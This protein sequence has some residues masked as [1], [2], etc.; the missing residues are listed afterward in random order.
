M[1]ISELYN[2][3]KD[4]S[5]KKI[6]AETKDY[7]IG[8]L[9]NIN[10][11]NTKE[12]AKQFIK[13]LALCRGAQAA[14]E[15]ENRTNTLRTLLS[16]G[17]DGAYVENDS[18]INDRF[19]YELI[20]N[21]DDC[22]YASVSDCKLKI[23]F[24]F[25]NDTL[26]LAYN[27]LG[28]RPKDVIAI[29]DIGNSTKNHHKSLDQKESGLEDADLIEIG[30]KGIGFKSIF[31][32]ADKVYIRSGYFGFYFDYSDFTIPK[33][34][35]GEENHVDGTEL[36]IYLKPEITKQ[37]YKM[38]ETKYQNNTAII[39]ENPILFLNKLTEI[40]YESDDGYFGL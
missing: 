40:I 4:K 27:E 3:Y 5:E 11:I 30:E 10:E 14:M 21:V 9:S 8:C 38:L 37:L 12:E 17:E 28:F 34:I 15:G 20:Q 35:E 39:N 18:Y 16:T 33:L 13:V 1:N 6:D 19:M 25:E 2:K 32:L 31:G 24:D 23:K 36:T 7:L 26:K 29:S 22:K